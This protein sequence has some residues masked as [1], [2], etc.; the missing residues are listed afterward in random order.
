MAR[1]DFEKWCACIKRFASHPKVYMKLSGGFSE[2]STERVSESSPEKLAARVKPWLD[3]VFECFG[4]ERIMFG[5][6]WPVCN[7]R[8][9]GTE[10]SWIIWKNLVDVAL[11]KQKLSVAQ[12]RRV[13][14]GT[15][16]EAYRLDAQDRV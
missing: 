15:A 3:Q 5:S 2:L 8:G 6:D 16:E 4:P 11:D 10:D 9:P 7:V 12:K 14:A 13:W 1:E